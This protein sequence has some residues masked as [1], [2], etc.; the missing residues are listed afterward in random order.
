M[1]QIEHILIPFFEKYPIQS[2]KQKDFI[3]FRTVFHWIRKGEHLTPEGIEKI[4][5]FIK[6][7]INL[8]E[9]PTIYFHR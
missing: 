6:R 2:R 3:K 5:K 8:R 7:K 4:Q 1:D 9:S